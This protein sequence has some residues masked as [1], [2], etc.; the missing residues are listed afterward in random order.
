MILAAAEIIQERYSSQT[1]ALS[2]GVW[3]NATLLAKTYGLLQT[4]GFKVLIHQTVP[5]NDGGIAFGQ[6]A[7]AHFTLQE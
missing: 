3:Q 5:A 4:N 1:I 7:A 2:G 6:A